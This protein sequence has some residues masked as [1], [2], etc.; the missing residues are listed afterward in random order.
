VLILSRDDGAITGSLPAR[1]LS[2]R[3][4]NDRTDRLYLASPQGT[5]VCLRPQGSDFPEYHKFPER[6][7]MLP[8]F[9]EELPYLPEPAA[10]NPMP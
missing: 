4:A 6:Q 2:L 5:L 1:E 3:A 10:E 7:P 8:E 9:A